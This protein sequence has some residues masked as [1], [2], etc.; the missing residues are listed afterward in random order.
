[1][2]GAGGRK[3]CPAGEDGDCAAREGAAG[4]G[5]GER[6]NETILDL[7]PEGVF[8]Q[9]LPLARLWGRQ[10]IWQLDSS[11]GPPLL[12]A[13]TWSASMSARG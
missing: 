2:E 11:V 6:R 7:F 4:E 3:K 5:G 13:A 1:M 12:Q 8:R 9:L 10:S